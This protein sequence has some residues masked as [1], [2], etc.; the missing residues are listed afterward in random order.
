MFIR[1]PYYFFLTPRS[2]NCVA[3]MNV[4]TAA[5]NQHKD[6]YGSLGDSAFDETFGSPLGMF[7]RI[8]SLQL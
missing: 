6:G 8:R 2:Y 4:G 1:C 7:Q 5:R 3:G